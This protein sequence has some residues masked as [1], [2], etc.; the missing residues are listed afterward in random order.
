METT[1]QPATG[2][3]R[4]ERIMAA[5]EGR[6]PD[7]PPVSFDCRADILGPVLAH[8]GAADKNDLY[9]A[10]GIDGFGVWEWNAIMGRYTGAPKTAAD[11]TPLDFWGSLYHHECG[12]D[13]CDT[14]EALVAHE[15]PTLSDFDFSHVRA[16]ALEI[17]AMDMAVAAGHLGLG[18]QMHNNLRGNEK[19]LLD[20]SDDGW[21][22]AYV[23]R[24]TAFTVGYIDALLTAG[25]GEIDVVR[26]DDDLGT[27]DRLMI[28]PAMWRRF[29]KPAWKAAFDVCHRHGAKVWFHSC[30]YIWPLLED[31]IEIGVDCWNP[32]A[33]YVKDNDHD[34]LREVRRGR[35]AL[36]GG[37]SQLILVGGTP[38]DARDETLR[39]LDTFAPDGGLLIGPSQ[40]FTEDI[41]LAN[42]VAFF[43]AAVGGR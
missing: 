42:I 33:P 7:R 36:D 21:M 35:L 18:Y 11:G 14:I 16:R 20:L 37:V 22:D 24:V 29:Y 39:V 15:W 3:S 17:K 34:R 8:Y 12:L 6:V 4:R 32:F 40:V 27:M 2:M 30:G 1:A 31:L 38:L 10:A 28:S 25:R 13:A 26:A 23:E 19:A 43:D 5:L 9:R 41:P